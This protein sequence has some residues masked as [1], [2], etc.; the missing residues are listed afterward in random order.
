MVAVLKHG[1]QTGFLFGV[2]PARMVL[3]AI[4]PDRINVDAVEEH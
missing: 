3:S 2:L 4:L 1:P